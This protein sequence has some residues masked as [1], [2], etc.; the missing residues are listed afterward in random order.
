[1]CFGT[2]GKA[3]S[4]VRAALVLTALLAGQ[5]DRNTIA[6]LVRDAARASS[7]DVLF[8]VIEEETGVSLETVTNRRTYRLPGF[9]LAAADFGVI[10]GARPDPDPSGS[11]RD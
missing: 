7:L 4:S 10:L 11:V 1:M 5:S 8:R 3:T 2:R 9:T 6:G